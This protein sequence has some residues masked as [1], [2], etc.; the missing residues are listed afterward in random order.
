M[1]IMISFMFFMSGI[2]FASDLNECE[3]QE[4]HCDSNARC[5]NTNG[6]FKCHCNDGYFG[7]GFHCSG[8]NKCIFSAFQCWY[9]AFQLRK[10]PEKCSK[11]FCGKYL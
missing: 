2:F 11:S 9:I 5:I 10:Y 4:N 6:S 3:L 1:K 8:V 7:D